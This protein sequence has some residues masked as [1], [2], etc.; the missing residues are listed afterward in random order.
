MITAM[1]NHSVEMDIHFELAPPP[2]LPLILVLALPRP[3]VLRRI[4]RN[5]AELGIE[6]LVLTASYRVEKSYWSTPLLQPSAVRNAL[7]EGLQQSGD[8]VLPHISIE[9]RFKPFVEDRLPALVG[10]GAAY[11]AHPGSATPCPQP[12]NK[13]A[14]VAIGPEGGFIPYEIDKLSEAGCQPISLGPRILKVDNAITSITSRLF[15][16]HWPT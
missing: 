13:A 15:D 16:C 7:I 3:K 10:A 11:V 2:K 5:C 8:T 4:L 9:K 6:K 1:N 14:L 12:L